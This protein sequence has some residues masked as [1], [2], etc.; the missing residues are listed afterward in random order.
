V[1][2]LIA[3]CEDERNF[4]ILIVTNTFRSTM[5]EERLNYLSILSVRKNITKLLAYEE[6]INEY[7][8]IHLVVCLTT[9]PKRL[10]KRTLHVV[11]SRASYFRCEHPLLSLRSSN[12][13][14]RLLPVTFI[15]PFYLSFNN[16]L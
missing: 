8:F 2:L 16:L 12:G 6:T 5:L 11:R 4:S 3:S 7:S 13:F 9:G 10:T 15:P 1:A 14:L